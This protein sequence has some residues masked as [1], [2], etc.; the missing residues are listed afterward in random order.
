MRYEVQ[1]WFLNE[2]VL[3]VHQFVS[4]SAAKDFYDQYKLSSSETLQLVKILEER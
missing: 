4:L 3:A 2:E 1:V